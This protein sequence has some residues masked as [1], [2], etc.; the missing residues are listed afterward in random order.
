MLNGLSQGHSWLRDASGSWNTICIRARIRRISSS[1]RLDKSTPSK[2]TRPEVGSY[3]FKTNRPMVDFPEPLSPANPK[4]SPRRIVKLT[5]STAF[6]VGILPRFNRVARKPVWIGEM[7]TQVF[8]PY[9]V[10]TCSRNPDRCGFLVD[11]P[12]S[13]HDESPACQWSSQQLP[14]GKASKMPGG[15]RSLAQKQVPALSKYP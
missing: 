10:F 11:G 9:Q 4:T 12:L 2:S 3:R 5:P 15:R 8:Y 7:F 1:G 14:F 6:T 13:S